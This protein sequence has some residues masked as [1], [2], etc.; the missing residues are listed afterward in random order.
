[1]AN[2]GQSLDTRG[3]KSVPEIVATFASSHLMQCG[4]LDGMWKS[5]PE[6]LQNLDDYWI[7]GLMSA[8]LAEEYRADPLLHG[9]YK[10]IIKNQVEL[11][12]HERR[13]LD[14]DFD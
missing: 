12:A 9:F 1:M 11:V 5:I 14:D 10:S 13:R 4:Y 8:R 7:H 2:L 6:R 3:E